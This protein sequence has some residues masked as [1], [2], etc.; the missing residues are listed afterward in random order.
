[1]TTRELDA[2]RQ[3]QPTALE[4]FFGGSLCKSET[5]LIVTLSSGV[6]NGGKWIFF[7]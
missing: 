3:K 1:M 4:K 5:S 2:A 6:E 7:L